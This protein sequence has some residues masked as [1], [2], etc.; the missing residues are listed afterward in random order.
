MDQDNPVRRMLDLAG[1]S[2]PFECRQVLVGFRKALMDANPDLTTDKMALYDAAISQELGPLIEALLQAHVEVASKSLNES[3]LAAWSRLAALP[4][5]QIFFESIRQLG[6]EFRAANVQTF[7]SKGAAAH[8]R[9]A[10]KLF[11]SL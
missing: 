11:E 7:R 3:Q 2:A 10:E 4:E 1:S 5:T 6:A 8:A 9:S